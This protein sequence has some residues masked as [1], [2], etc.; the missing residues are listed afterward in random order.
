MCPRSSDPFYIVSDY[1]KRVTTSWTHSK[2]QISKSVKKKKKWLT[3]SRSHDG[4]LVWD[5]FCCFSI[6]C[7]LFTG[8]IFGFSSHICYFMHIFYSHVQTFFREEFTRLFSPALRIFWLV[9]CLLCC[10]NTGERGVY[11]I[12]FVGSIAMWLLRGVLPTRHPDIRILVPD[13][14]SGYN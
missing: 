9:C 6:W 7:H 11:I 12:L 2:V 4:S 3:N 13:I 14:K 8:M 1:I 10:C 5:S